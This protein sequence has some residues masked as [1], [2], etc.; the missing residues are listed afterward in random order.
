MKTMVN[1]DGCV[2]FFANVTNLADALMVL[3]VNRF[4]KFSL[5]YRRMKVRWV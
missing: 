4:C 2:R 1:L 3:V 5:A